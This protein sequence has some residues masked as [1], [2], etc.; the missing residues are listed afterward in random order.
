MIIGSLD[1][2]TYRLSVVDDGLDFPTTVNSTMTDVFFVNFRCD[3]LSA[4]LIS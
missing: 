2:G 4:R 3:L 1:G